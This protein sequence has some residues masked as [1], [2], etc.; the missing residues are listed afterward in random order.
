MTHEHIYIQHPRQVA[1][2]CCSE[3]GLAV[4]KSMLRPH[5][6][7]EYSLAITQAQREQ[8]KPLMEVA[9]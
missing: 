9:S 1:M 3:C 2:I 7:R 8:L 6:A 4:P 5:V